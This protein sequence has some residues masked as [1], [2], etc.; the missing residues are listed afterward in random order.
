MPTDNRHIAISHA[1]IGTEPAPVPGGRC[2]AMDPVDYGAVI[3]T[4]NYF[5]YFNGA[6]GLPHGFTVAQ[7]IWPHGTASGTRACSAGKPGNGMNHGFRLFHD[8]GVGPWDSAK[9]TFGCRHSSGEDKTL[10]SNIPHSTWSFV[11]A[12]E[13]Q[14]GDVI[15]CHNGEL[16][17]SASTNAPQWNV[18]DRPLYYGQTA[19]YGAPAGEQSDWRG[20]L[21]PLFLWSRAMSLSELQQVR[22]DPLVMW[23]PP[24]IEV[25][26]GGA[27]PLAGTIDAVSGADAALALAAKLAGTVDAVSGADADL[28]L[29]AKLAGDVAAVSGADA[30][31]ELAA[32]LAGTVD[33]QSAVDGA[34]TISADI[35]LAGT[36]DAVSGAAASLELAA[37]LA[38]TVAAVSG[39]DAAL[40]VGTVVSLAGTIAAQSGVDATLGLDLGLV[41]T[42]DAATAADAALELVVGL[43]GTVDAAATAEA[44]LAMI[45]QL[46]GQVDG[47]ST[48]EGRLS[49]L[50]EVTLGEVIDPTV[51]S[52]T[53]A[54]T[55]ESQTRAL[56]W[57]SATVDRTTENT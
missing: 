1:N 48:V 12:S 35:F 32:K 6:G 50:G 9:F 47:Q 37:K 10:F 36:V 28:N 44:A 40:T 27:V 2:I 11:A 57:E 13:D 38:A 31:L 7:W 43:V 24:V 41:G 3:R 33:A 52:L 54:P 29:A 14:N 49:I 26:V 21:G 56:T 55:I 20:K 19:N 34:L 51:E 45:Y 25:A 5:N 23:R 42:V 18:A 17:V 15:L 30:S 16:D 4:V 39:A 46:D 22:R 53:V 8:V